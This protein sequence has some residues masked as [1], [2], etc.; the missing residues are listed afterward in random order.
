MDVGASLEQPRMGVVT[1][2]A[3]QTQVIAAGKAGQ[4]RAR[5][6]KAEPQKR[7]VEPVC[8]AAMS[9]SSAASRPLLTHQSITPAV[10]GRS[11]TFDKLHAGLV[12]LLRRVSPTHMRLFF[13]WLENP[14]GDA[15][16]C[17][18]HSQK[19]H[20]QATHSR[21]CSAHHMLG[22]RTDNRNPVQSLA[23]CTHSSGRHG[24]LPWASTL[25]MQSRWPFMA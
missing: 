8:R 4:G 14:R 22:C 7:V 17:T 12:L 13:T 19:M 11:A 21:S 1:C 2:T 24:T 15:L 23:R 5:P 3:E 25:A 6:G 16:V 10:T 18:A 20:L 9:R